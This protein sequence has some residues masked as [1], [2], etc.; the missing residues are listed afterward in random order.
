MMSTR[1]RSRHPGDPRDVDRTHR[2]LVVMDPL[3]A[4]DPT[5]DS[6]FAMLLEAQRLEWSCWYAEL[7]DLWIRDGVAWGRVTEVRVRDDRTR[8]FELGAAT[9]CRL[10]DFDVILMRKDPPFDTEYVFATYVLERAEAG[11]ALVV[12]R[13]QSLRDANEKAFVAW[14]PEVTAPTLI[15]RS[16]S[17]LK[18]FVQEHGRA[19]VKPLD[20][21]AGRAVFV[22]GVDD[23]NLNVLL[24][25]MTELGTRYALAQRYLPAIQESGDARILLIDGEPVPT[26]L[27]RHPP[28]DDHR[29]NISVGART[30]CRPLTDD[31][32]RV[33]KALGPV[34]REKGLLFVGIDVIGGWLTEINVTSPTGIRELERDGGLQVTSALFDAIKSGIGRRPQE[35]ARLRTNS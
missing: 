2:L 16:R 20:K 14:F 1:S 35:A 21:M 28:A 12:N 13:P 23:P 17:V 9:D 24:D 10:S 19:V 32:R 18:A 31:E 4:I 8:W 3:R 11:G 15:A 33:C 30:E 6:S 25:T 7:G 29:G 34:L 22:T 5:K 27:V 26:A